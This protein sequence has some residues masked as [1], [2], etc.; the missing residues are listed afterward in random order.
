M[1]VPTQDG[2]ER[3]F[4]LLVPDGEKL[5]IYWDLTCNHFYDTQRIVTKREREYPLSSTYLDK[6]PFLYG[7]V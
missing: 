5:L 6:M 1:K 3:R 7:K 4:K 2:E